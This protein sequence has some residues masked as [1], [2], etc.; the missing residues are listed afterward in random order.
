MY[1]YL[2]FARYLWNRSCGRYDSTLIMFDRLCT[3]NANIVALSCN[4]WYSGKAV[5]VTY[6][7]ILLFSLR[8][9]ACNAHG[10]YYSVI[11]RLPCCTV[12]FHSISQ[13]ARFKKKK[14]SLSRMKYVFDFLYIL[15]WNISHSKKNWARCDQT[16]IL[17]F[18]CSNGHSYQILIKLEFSRQNFEKYWNKHFLDN[19]SAKSFHADGRTYEQT[20]RQI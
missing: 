5:S 19:P 20:D 10:A 9:P 13:T 7:E 14:K 6:S 15:F 4:L 12:F 3:Y 2:I 1:F 18:M 16:C 11:C 8:Y 17:V